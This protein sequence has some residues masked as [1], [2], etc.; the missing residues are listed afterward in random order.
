[1]I[2]NP[3]IDPAFVQI[4]SLALTDQIYDL[5]DFDP[6]GFQWI[7]PDF[8]LVTNPI[9]HALCGGFTYAATFMNNVIDMTTNPMKYDTLTRTYTFYSEDFAL[10][11][12][13]P[14]TLEAHL[15]D[16]PVTKTAV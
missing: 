2:K 15:T 12:S 3:C 10:I 7:H 11:G 1:M 4:D 5:Y 14:F 6:V 13:Q 16:Y 9:S 8:V